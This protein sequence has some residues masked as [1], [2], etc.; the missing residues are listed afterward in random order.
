MELERALEAL[1]VLR[2]LT[3]VERQEAERLLAIKDRK[4]G[5]E[6]I[7]IFIKGR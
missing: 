6:E 5:R 3:I 7:G 4:L 2:D 1:E